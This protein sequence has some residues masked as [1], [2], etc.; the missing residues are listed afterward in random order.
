[1]GLTSI[2]EKTAESVGVDVSDR[3]RPLDRDPR[4]E[5]NAAEFNALRDA[6]IANASTI[7]L[8]DGSTAGSL[9]ARVPVD[10]PVS[11]HAVKTTDDT[12]APIYVDP[13]PANN[14]QYE[15]LVSARKTTLAAAGAY[16]IF[17]Y[18]AVRSVDSEAAVTV[19]S[20]AM[21][22]DTGPGVTNE[23]WSI[24]IQDD[25]AGTLEV[26]VTG[27]AQSTVQWHAVVRRWATD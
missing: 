22:A 11:H 2:P 12:P 18:R 17:S 23:T 19:A 13:L 4:Y 8:A 9:E 5:T 16:G 27:A 26:E 7:G 15:I 3:P 1:M 25:G 20:I 6:V 21:H 10:V 14:A 24:A